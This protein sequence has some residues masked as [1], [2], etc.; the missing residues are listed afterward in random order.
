MLF[1]FLLMFGGGGG[2]GC[3]TNLVRVSSGFIRAFSGL[4]D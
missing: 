2:R 1:C 3:H 4:G